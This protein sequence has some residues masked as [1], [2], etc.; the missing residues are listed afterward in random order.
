MSI[1]FVQGL[2]RRGRRTIST[3]KVRNKFAFNRVIF[4]T[5]D[6]IGKYFVLPSIWIRRDLFFIFKLLRKW[7]II[8]VH[9]W[10]FHLVV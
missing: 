7:T 10:G 6:V 1:I 8:L 5:K 3:G 9:R 4:I 2:R